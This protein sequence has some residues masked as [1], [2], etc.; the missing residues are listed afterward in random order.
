MKYLIVFKKDVSK[1]NYKILF[2]FK[3][4]TFISTKI[5]VFVLINL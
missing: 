2:Y 4:K 5:K 1:I 3:H